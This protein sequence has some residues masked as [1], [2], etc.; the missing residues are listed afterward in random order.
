MIEGLLIWAHS[1]CRSTL[2]FYEGLGTAFVVPIR[3]LFWQKGFANRSVIGHSNDEF[4]HLD[5][6]FIG[7]DFS[8]AQEEFRRHQ[9]W[10]Q[11]FGTYQEGGVFRKML[12]KAGQAG[13]RVAIASEAPC[14]MNPFP[15]HMAKEVFIKAVLK[16]K[17][18][19]HLK[20]A[21]F[22]LNLSGNQVHNLKRIGWPDHKIVPCGYYSPPPS[23]QPVYSSDSNA[24]A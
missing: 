14:N 24:L 8:V 11:F 9:K 18:S 2:A 7:D 12:L 4:K 17:I 6:R 19:K 23:R 13:C 1:Y 21:D 20:T 10:H 15:R 16:H 3:L 5:M 22:I